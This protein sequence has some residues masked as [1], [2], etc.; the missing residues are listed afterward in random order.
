MHKERDKIVELA[1]KI[2]CDSFCPSGSNTK[3]I[4]DFTRLERVDIIEK[5]VTAAVEFYS[6]IDIQL[7]KEVTR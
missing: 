7:G 5:S 1:S 3:R 4:S 2:M 6:E